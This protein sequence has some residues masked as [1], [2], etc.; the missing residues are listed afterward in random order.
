MKKDVKSAWRKWEN[1]KADHSETVAKINP[2]FLLFIIM[3]HD[4]I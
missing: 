4:M 2:Y 3:F 1:I